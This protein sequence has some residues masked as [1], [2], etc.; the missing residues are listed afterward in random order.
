MKIHGVYLTDEEKK[1]H[2]AESPQGARRTLCLRKI[3]FGMKLVYT[4]HAMKK[5]RRGGIDTCGKCAAVW[6]M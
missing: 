3:T 1:R 4:K 5:A 2:G 6:S